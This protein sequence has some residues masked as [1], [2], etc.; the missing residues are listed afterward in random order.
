MSLDFRALFAIRL[1]RLYACFSGI[2][3]IQTIRK[4]IGSNGLM[5]ANLNLKAALGFNFLK[6][7]IMLFSLSKLGG[8]Y[9]GQ[10]LFQQEFS[11]VNTFLIL[12]FGMQISGRLRFLFEGTYGK[13]GQFSNWGLDGVLVWVI[14]F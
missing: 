10:I 12:H 7:L 11:K 8:W 9:N 1:R 4:L 13:L 6:H 3:V 5:C 2:R 14:W